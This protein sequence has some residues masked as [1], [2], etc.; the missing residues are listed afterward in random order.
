MDNTYFLQNCWIRTKQPSSS[1]RVDGMDLSIGGGCKQNLRWNHTAQ[2][3]FLKRW[4]VDFD[5]TLE[6]LEITPIWVCLIGLPLIFWSEDIFRELGNAIS[7]LYKAYLSFQNPGYMAMAR[8]L[9]GL[10]LFGGLAD[11]TTIQHNSISF[12]P[13]LDYKGI[14][15][16]CGRCHTYG[17]LMKE[18]SRE[19]KRWVK[20]A[21]MNKEVGS[22]NNDKAQSHSPHGTMRSSE[23]PND[24]QVE[25]TGEKGSPSKDPS[26]NLSGTQF[27]SSPPTFPSYSFNEDL[28]LS[29]AMVQQKHI[30][31]ANSFLLGLS[32]YHLL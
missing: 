10:K 22:P 24:S 26:D 15:F 7:F 9:V 21:V 32:R 18:C 23:D 11:S 13:N 4:M 3:L 2:A 6:R 1:K 8:I 5:A 20:K 16:G 25:D 27:S 17:H 14:P 28:V 31:P 19:E 30:P 29:S 12:Q